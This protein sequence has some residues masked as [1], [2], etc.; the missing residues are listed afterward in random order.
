MTFIMSRPLYQQGL[1]DYVDQLAETEPTLKDAMK[2][3]A[4]ATN[5]ATRKGFI[6]L[7]ADEN[8]TFLLHA[9]HHQLLAIINP[10]H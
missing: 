8:V 6:V 3:T 5:A 7:S 1:Q 10:A 4:I 9:G 2:L